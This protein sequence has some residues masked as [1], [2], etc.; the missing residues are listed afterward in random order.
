M[1]SFHQGGT[2]KPN[3]SVSN[4]NLKVK[5]NLD[6]KKCLNSDE[7]GGAGPRQVLESV[8]QFRKK[9]ALFGLRMAIL[10]SKSP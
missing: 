5:K 3:I 9:E 8:W 2:F 4:K 1:G 10:R 7:A 6:A